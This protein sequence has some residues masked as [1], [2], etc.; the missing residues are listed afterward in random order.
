MLSHAGLSGSYYVPDDVEKWLRPGESSPWVRVSDFLL[1]GD[2]R[3]NIR[4]LATR[5]RHTEGF[6]TGRV[7]GKLEFAVGPERRSASAPWASIKQGPQLLMTWPHDF[8]AAADEI[9]DRGRLSD[10]QRG[11]REEDRFAGK[12]DRPLPGPECEPVLAEGLGRPENHRPRTRPSCGGSASMAPTRLLTEPRD[13]SAF[14]TAHGLQQHFGL[15]EH[16]LLTKND[17]QSQPDV[18]KIDARMKALASRQ[19]AHPGSRGALQAGR[20]ASRH[21]L[22]RTWSRVRSVVKSSS[23][24]SRLRS[25][26]RVS[27]A[28]Q[29]GTRLSLSC[30]ADRQKHPELFYHTGLFRLHALA[31]RRPVGD[32]CQAALPAGK[33]QDLRQLL[34]AIVGGADLGSAR[35]RS[36]LHPAGRRSGHGL[37]GRLARLW[38]PV[39]NR[40]P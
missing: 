10:T 18:A 34:A 19:H 8:A 37:D 38:Q 16:L 24:I 28:S 6:V 40:Y 35:D 22:Q 15:Y 9:L 31:Q 26:R 11:R 30:P 2:G 17:C 7:R 3:N 13:A 32:G 21:V 4:L 33:R 39:R 27:W 29:V 36:L 25:G 20:R 14:Y 5:N 12:T 1:P 23:P